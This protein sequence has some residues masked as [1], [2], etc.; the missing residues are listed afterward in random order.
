MNWRRWLPG[1]IFR[2]ALG[3]VTL[4]L[5]LLMG[6]DLLVGLTPDRY[7]TEVRVRTRIAES[8]A[9]QITAML[10]T[11]DMRGLTHVLHGVLERDAELTSVALRRRDGSLL[12]RVGDH[13]TLWS[14]P[15]DAPSTI[16]NVRVPL[17][18]DGQ[19]WGDVEMSFAPISPHTVQG[20]LEDSRVH[21]MVL[22][23]VSALF[24]VYLYLRRALQYLDP[25]NAIPQR[26]S[27]AFDTLTEA[28][29]LLDSDLR[30]VLTNSAFARLHADAGKSVL[31]RY[32]SQLEWLTGNLGKDRGLWAWNV[33]AR[34]REA[35]EEELIEL[36]G[37]EGLAPTKL[38][39]NASPILD[40]D[41][42][43]RGC[44]VSLSDVSQ[45]HRANEALLSALQALDESSQKIQQQNRELAHLATR[46]PLTGCFNRRAF[47]DKVSQVMTNA[48]R[49]GTA[50]SCV[51][52]DID[53][54]KSFND[55]YGHAVGDQV[56]VAVAAALQRGIRDG[57]ILCRYGGEEFCIVLPGLNVAGAR[58]VAER[59]RQSIEEMADANLRTTSR[60]K[61]TASFG[62]AQ[63]NA[64]SADVEDM[65][66]RAD[67]ALYEAKRGGRNRVVVD[68]CGAADPAG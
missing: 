58:S 48:A 31:G 35:V 64:G 15:E 49:N 54:F 42:H 27:A 21:A 68:S 19:H 25:G 13:D 26:V 50:V 30:V 14:L 6:L 47:Y 5:C 55:T 66:Q 63:L 67:A 23:G 18:A 3:V 11:D 56:L 59:L 39:L 4:I 8:L 1:P 32:A 57:D 51:M 38:R 65:I 46:D 44:I 37:A 22:V 2:L 36:Q 24:L 29:M 10:R 40:G 61:I 53:H 45:L 12:A 33:V 28:V 62:I 9:I 34:N 7:S 52:T 16:T 60:L 41:G 17:H 43:F 20:W